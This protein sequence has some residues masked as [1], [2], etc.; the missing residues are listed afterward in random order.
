MYI[1]HRLSKNALSHF[2]SKFLSIFG[3]F[4]L[5]ILTWIVPNFILVHF[6]VQVSSHLTYPKSCLVALKGLKMAKNWLKLRFLFAIFH[7]LHQL[8]AH[9]GPIIWLVLLQNIVLI[10]FSYHCSTP[11]YHTGSITVPIL[12]FFIPMSQ[13]RVY[14]CIIG[15]GF[16]FQY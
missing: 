12:Y 7:H 3:P 10:N 15:C 2:F 6:L 16:Y 5:N 14:L 11:S 9:F 1:S 13:N 4:W 8:L